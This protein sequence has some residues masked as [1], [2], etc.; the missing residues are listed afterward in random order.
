MSEAL[1]TWTCAIIGTAAVCSVLLV[2]TPEG[3]VKEVVRLLCGV[4]VSAAIL[5]PL[6]D[7]DYSS[8]SKG[9]AEYRLEAESLTASAEEESKNLNRTYIEEKCQAYILDKAASCG[10]KLIS[11][12]VRAQWST[13]GYWYPV[14]AEISAQADEIK[15]DRIKSIIEAEL[16]IPRE[17][18]RWTDEG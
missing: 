16:G 3:R 13:D 8:F 15:T 1:R 4:A 7:M 14:Y 17:N 18:Q 10:V 11:V 12:R 6:I 2:L 9:L 5:S